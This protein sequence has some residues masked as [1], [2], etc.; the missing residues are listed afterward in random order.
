MINPDELDPPRPVLKPLDMQ[1]MSVSELQE[2]IQA[3]QI[4]IKRTQDMIDKK[5]AHK[6]GIEA[7]FGPPKG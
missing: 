3:L 7:L 5:E 1:Q 4:E 6:S 2:Y